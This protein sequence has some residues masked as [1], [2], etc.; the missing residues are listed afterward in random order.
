M[1]K[2]PR[3]TL[4]TA[5]QIAPTAR[6]TLRRHPER[7]RHDRAA[8]E[9]ILDEA[10]FCHV[11]FVQDGQPYAVPTIHARMGRT[12]Y[13][14]GSPASRLLRSLSGG[15]PVC[16]TA[17]I[18][19]GLVLARSAFSSSMNYRSAVVLGIAEPVGNAREKHMAFGALVD[20]VAPGRSLEAR[21]PTLE[22]ARKTLVLRIP[23]D[24]GS[25][26]V[27]TGPP[28]DEADDVRLPIWA[29]VLPLRT[30]A[31]SPVP[32]PTLDPGIPLPRSVTGWQ[33]ARAAG[34]P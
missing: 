32:D 18:L 6:T 30:V 13:L 9:A 5:G 29:G 33:P 12:L 16:V 2:T 24:E 8:L 26:K 15:I 7:G 22:E 19:D 14:H 31:G 11:G 28:L 10:L 21:M 34:P 20:H 1:S 3:A 23:I 4:R 17:T 25:A 27:R